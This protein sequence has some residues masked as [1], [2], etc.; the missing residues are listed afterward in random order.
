MI[1]LV[2]LVPVTSVRAQQP[3]P[4]VAD[5]ADRPGFAD[6]PILLKRGQIQLESGLSWENEGRSTDLAKTITWPQ[7]ELHGGVATRLEV[8]I[9]WDGLVS[10]STA[11]SSSDADG[12]ST[13]LANVRLGAKFAVASGPKYDA[14]VIGYAFLPVG[15][16]SVSSRY[17][18]PLARFAWAV[19]LNDRFSLAGTAD[20]G[21]E[22]EDDGRVRP[23]P[24]ASAALGSTVVGA[25]NGFAGIVAESPPVGSRP[26]V[27]SIEGGLMLPI[28]HLTEIDVWISRRLS[29]GP[30]DWAVGAGFVRRLREAR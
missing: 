20:I 15:S 10:A 18:D 24:A 13:G 28:K 21:A 6:S 7:L 14:A 17:V 26:D 5:A 2:G 9:S 30:D 4:S 11:G 22:R 1:A 19:A 29:G 27:W 16:D 23:K 12:R 25:L 8:S 3:P